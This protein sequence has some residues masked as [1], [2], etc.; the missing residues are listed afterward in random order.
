MTDNII[1]TDYTSIKEVIETNLVSQVNEFLELGWEIIGTSSGHV[2]DG[3]AYI[4]YSLGW[5]QPDK[6]VY[7]DPHKHDKIK[8]L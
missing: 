5:K 1:E 6:P 3:E 7:P 8:G 4:L 2:E